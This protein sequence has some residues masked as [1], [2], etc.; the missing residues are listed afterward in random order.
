ME[1]ARKLCLEVSIDS[2][3]WSIVQSKK[4]KVD[5]RVILIVILEYSTG[6]P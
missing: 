2:I 3:R 1:T 6:K 5:D 4:L